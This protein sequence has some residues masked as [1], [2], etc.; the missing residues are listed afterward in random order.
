MRRSADGCVHSGGTF[1]DVSESLWS[2]QV[3]GGGLDNQLF[4]VIVKRV[5]VNPSST[6]TAMILWCD[7]SGGY[8]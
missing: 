2:R 3:R 6:T 8:I 7:A 1:I 5:F 4:V